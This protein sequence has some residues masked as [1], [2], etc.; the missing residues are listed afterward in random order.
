MVLPLPPF[1]ASAS[2]LASVPGGT[3]AMN[4]GARVPEV[5]GLVRIRRCLDQPLAERHHATILHRH[6]QTIHAHRHFRDLRHFDDLDP[7]LG[8]DRREVVGRLRVSLVRQRRRHCVH[9]ERVGLVRIGAVAHAALEVGHL[10]HDVAHRRPGNRRVFR[11]PWPFG[12]WQSPHA[13]MPSF[14]RPRA[15]MSGI[16]GWSPGYQSTGP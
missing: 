11:F 7:R 10:L 1:V 6:E 5:T 14:C 2:P 16:F 9:L 3:Y 15:T 12:K 13:R 8:L 4:S